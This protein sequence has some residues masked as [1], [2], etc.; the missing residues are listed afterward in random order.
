MIF[1]LIFV[2]ITVYADNTN[3][4]PIPAGWTNANTDMAWGIGHPSVHYPV[5]WQGKTTIRLD[6]NPDLI[7]YGWPSISEAN[8][9]S[10]PIKPGDRIVFKASI[11]AGPSTTGETGPVHGAKIAL[12]MYGS[13]GRIV[14]IST[15][16]GDTGWPN[17]PEERDLLC[18]RWGSTQWKQVTMDFIVRDSYMA[19]PDG[20]YTAGTMV[21]PLAF[22]PIV[23]TSTHQPATE[24]GSIY[25]ADTELHINPGETPSSEV[26]VVISTTEGGT[27]SPP[28]GTYTVTKGAYGEIEAIPD[29]THIFSHWEID[30]VDYGSQ[31]P[32]TGPA[33][34]NLSIL[35][36][37]ETPSSE[38]TAAPSIEIWTNKATYAR[39]KTMSVYIQVSNPSPATTVKIIAKI[40]LSGGGTYGLWTIWTGTL[41]A[42]YNSGVVFWKSFPIP[43]STA[44][45]TYSWIAELRKPATNALID[46]DTWTW[47]VT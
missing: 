20:A 45:G 14:E 38:V 30:G 9:Y 2:P 11:W 35:A 27:T 19:D 28:P 33:N 17:W 3:L 12:D 41:P 36:V 24:A 8:S 10:I 31:N 32:L 29:S 43:Y 34:A 1:I 16:D 4:A 46:L 25:F 15:P 44:V 47:T 23:H 37:F 5:S 18:A 7:A 26:T 13:R 39:G 42:G 6:R 22:I 21:T 40:G